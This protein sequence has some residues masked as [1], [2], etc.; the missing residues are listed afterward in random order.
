M[1]KSKKNFRKISSF[2]QNKKIFQSFYND[3]HGIKKKLLI[4]DAVF[5]R[6]KKYSVF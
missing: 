3:A 6:L 4:N 5:A 2:H 1:N